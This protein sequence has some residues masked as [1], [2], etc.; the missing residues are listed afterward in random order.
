MSFYAKIKTQMSQKQYLIAALKELE[1]RGE[2]VSYQ[3]SEKTEAIE[4]DRDGDLL[5]VAQEK[6]G[7][8]FE[9]AGDVRI[10]RN[11]ADRL[12]QMYAYESIKDNIPLDFEIAEETERAGEIEILLK[13]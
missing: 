7:T 4:V 8:N 13:G 6:S 5:N 3:V 10:A 9:V 2:I 12:K 1:K 11:F